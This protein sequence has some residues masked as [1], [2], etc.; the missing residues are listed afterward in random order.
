MYYE[1][2]WLSDLAI[3][4][5]WELFLSGII[6][7]MVGTLIIICID[8]NRT[9]GIHTMKGI[10]ISHYQN[11][12][13][14]EQVKASG[15]DFAI[16]K[17]TEGTYLI[18][19][20]AFTFYSEAYQM[21]FPVGCYCYSHAMNAQQAM[22]EAAFLADAINGFPMPCGIYLDIEEEEQ[23]ALSHDELLNIIRGWCAGIG[24]RGYIPGIYSSAGTL[25]A[26]VS[27]NEVPDGCL[28]WIA[29]WSDHQPDTPCDLW[30]NSDS[31]RVEGYDGPVD[32]DVARSDR[33]RALVNLGYPARKE[34]PAAPDACPIDGPCEQEKEPEVSGAFA[35]LAEFLQT[36]EFQ[37]AF[38][39]YVK[40][41]G[42]D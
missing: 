14:M 39:A 8:R 36:E 13:R 3:I 40:R 31:G 34:E 9:G 5:A 11:G 22:A 20:S 19:A 28:V 1:W 30:Q 17:L 24:G 33:F 2:E 21:K 16:I 23:L 15:N 25:W 18:D 7:G 27:P 12:L 37:N 26:K 38:L 42:A 32:T 35:V 6:C 10:D 29:K 41:K 4:P